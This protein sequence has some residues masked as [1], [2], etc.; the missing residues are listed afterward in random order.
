M[1]LT[2]TPLAKVIYNMMNINKMNSIMIFIL[3]PLAKVIS[4]IMN[5][6]KMNS[7]MTIITLTPLA[8]V[9]QSTPCLLIA[10][11]TCSLS[12]SSS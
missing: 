8:R 5:I 9:P 11:L 10:P 6:N 3:T 1:I 7:I 12:S 4:N 2:L